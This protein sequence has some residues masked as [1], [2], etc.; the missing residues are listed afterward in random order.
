MG[1]CI[2]SLQILS[3]GALASAAWGQALPADAERV[4]L[5]GRSLAERS[6]ALPTSSRL[7]LTQSDTQPLATAAQSGA[8]GAWYGQ[9]PTA[10]QT[11]LWAR[12]WAGRGLAVGLG[13]EQRGAMPGG[14]PYSQWR[15]GAGPDS[16][17]LLG[18]AVP[19]SQNTAVTLQTP[20]YESAQPGYNELDTLRESRQVRVG[21]VFAKNKPYADLRKG[22][23]MELS[24][25]SSLTFRPRG[26]R[27]GVTF[28]STW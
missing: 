19:T 12:P 11:M 8:V 18:L 25:Q 15:H 6:A 20:L 27:V 17:V 14:G 13:V 16:G 4:G 23:R 26:G 7:R 5:N 9:S 22:F 3:L 24:G 28:Q 1:T 10:R 2:R 21:L